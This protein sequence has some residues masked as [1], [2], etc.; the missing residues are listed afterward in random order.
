MLPGT[1]SRLSPPWQDIQITGRYEPPHPGSF[2]SFKIKNGPI[3][4]S[5]LAKHESF[6]GSRQFA[7]IQIN[8]PFKYWKHRHVFVPDK[9]IGCILQDQIE[10]ALPF[11]LHKI[12]IIT[13][14]LE[15]LLSRLFT[16]RHETTKYDLRLSKK[17]NRE[18]KIMKILLTGAGGLIGSTL[19]ALLSTQ[20]HLVLRAVRD[21]E[22]CNDEETV[23]WNPI[24]GEIDSTKL[25]GLDAVIHLAGENIASGRWTEK[26]KTRI[27]ES[28]VHGTKVLADA[29]AKSNNPPSVFICASAIGFYGEQGDSE[30]TEDS[31]PGNNFL[32]EVCKDWEDSSK[33]VMKNGIRLVNLRIG[34]VLSPKGGALKMM[35]PPFIFGAGGNLGSGQ[36]YMS[37]ISIDDLARAIYHCIMTPSV[38]GPVNAV[39]S[40]PV[41]NA[42][43]TTTLGKVLSRPT[44]IPVP[45][46]M[47]K[48][49]LGEMADELL[50]S[51]SRVKPEK[52][53]SSGFEFQ[54][55][56]LELALRHLLGKT[57]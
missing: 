57:K 28:R 51:S 53:V 20:G 37:W 29:L 19:T 50:L 55:N 5:W 21:K 10:Y 13:N 31:P 45:A 2:L 16:F 3:F 6:K 30:L 44:L 47:A 9:D 4:I 12:Q 27:R 22:K 34:V 42:K 56:N 7:D 49:I 17:F 46:F 26:T 14:I 39:S 36:Q 52:L 8:G 43:F 11:N 41:T 32:A 33:S 1:F 35:L 48:L 25:E 38:S 23:Y 40:E 18:E 54:H 24:T 15:N